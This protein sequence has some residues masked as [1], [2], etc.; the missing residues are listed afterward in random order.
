[1]TAKEKAQELVLKYLNL[2]PP[3][4]DDHS[5]IYIPTAKRCALVAIDEIIESRKEDNGFDDTIL[6][7]AAKYWTA[8]PM[9]LTY[10]L[11]VKQ[12]IEKI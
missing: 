7:T 11:E 12:E 5:R 4:M 10:W 3:K 9:Y 8:H 2:E 1:M 6:S